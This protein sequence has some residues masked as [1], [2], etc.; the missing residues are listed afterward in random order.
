MG[1]EDAV[2]VLAVLVLVIMTL[3]GISIPILA[4]LGT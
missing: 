3:Y 1:T 4:A 2:M